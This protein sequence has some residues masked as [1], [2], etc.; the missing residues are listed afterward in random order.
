MTAF[1]FR[2]ADAPVSTELL[3]GLDQQDIDSILAA[4]RP[5]HFRASS[6]MTRQADP[7]NRLF[8]LWKGRA[9]YFFYTPNG[10]KLILRWI[11][12]GDIFGSAALAVPPTT[13]LVGAEAVRDSTVFSWDGVTVRDLTRRFPKLM[14]NVF[15]TTMDYLSWYV[16]AHAALASQTAQERLA[17]VLLRYAPSIGQKVSGGIEIDV[18]NDELAN[19]AN[20][21]PYTT[22]R[23]IREW[24]RSGAISKQRGKILLRSQE[25]LFRSRTLK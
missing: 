5:R 15:L 22:S 12:P 3:R 13:Y 7:A 2:A 23:L 21:T 9:R 8:L 16:S 6:V 20:I 18:T 11:I 1:K 25:K 24:H 19:A 10:K 14:T 4:A 17:H